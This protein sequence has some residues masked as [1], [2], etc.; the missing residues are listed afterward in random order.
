VTTSNIGYNISDIARPKGPISRS[1]IY[2]AINLGKLKA[3]KWGRRTI[4]TPEA[5]TEFLAS[6]PDYKTAA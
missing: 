2:T 4:I 6:L 5:W 3:K 1:E